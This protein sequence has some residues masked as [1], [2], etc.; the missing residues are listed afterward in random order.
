MRK[1][2]LLLALALLLGSAAHAFEDTQA[3]WAQEYIERC[4]EQE[5]FNGISETRFDP[6]G[7]M[8]RAM[9]VTV[10]GRLEGVDAENWSGDERFFADV[11]P[12]AYYAPYVAWAVCSGMVNGMTPTTFEPDT[13]ITREQIAMAGEK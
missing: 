5:L 4:V 6:D 9:F 7:I 3:H 10:L 8:T 12:Q 2:C 13:P 1:L 11:D